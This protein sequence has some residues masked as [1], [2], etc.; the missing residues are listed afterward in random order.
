MLFVKQS[1]R[2]EPCFANRVEIKL[3]LNQ[4][5]TL[6]RELESKMIHIALLPIKV[7]SVLNA[8]ASKALRIIR[9]MKMLNFGLRI[10]KSFLRNLVRVQMDAQLIASTRS[11]IMSLEMCDGQLSCSKRQIACQEIIG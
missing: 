2:A 7:M 9:H 6:E 3:G 10:L 11:A 1:A 5:R 4:R 8:G